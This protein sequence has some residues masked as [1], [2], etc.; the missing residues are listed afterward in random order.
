[1]SLRSAT[2]LR[3]LAPLLGVLLLFAG[4]DARAESESVWAGLIYATN[5]AKPSAPPESLAPVA[6]KL[7]KIFGYNQ[8]V[9]LGEAQRPVSASDHEEWLI[10]GKPFAL[11]VQVKE[12]K[13]AAADRAV[14][15]ARTAPSFGAMPNSAPQLSAPSI[16]REAL[17]SYRL[18][19]ALYQGDKYIVQT[20]VDLDRRSPIFIRGPLY[21][22]GQLI[23]M[24]QVN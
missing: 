16:S 6:K 12:V 19:L 15:P 13:I 2:L 20:D 17:T 9:L 1:M 5:E 7:R 4:S 24:L 23:L 3:P 18:K 11:T 14:L 8:F 22:N 10:A 21:S